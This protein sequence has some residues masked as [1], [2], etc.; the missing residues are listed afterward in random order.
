MLFTAV[1]FM[2]DNFLFGTDINFFLLA[3]KEA[4]AFNDIS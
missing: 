2:H 3:D 4:K 1:L